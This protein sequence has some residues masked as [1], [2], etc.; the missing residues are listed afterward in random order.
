MSCHC[1]GHL[2]WQSA[3]CC[4]DESGP[5]GGGEA[6]ADEAGE[7]DAVGLALASRGEQVAAAGAGPRVVDARLIGDDAVAVGRDAIEMTGADIL[8]VGT[9]NEVEA[10][11]QAHPRRHRAAQAEAMASIGTVAIA[12][13]S[14][15]PMRSRAQAIALPKTR[16]A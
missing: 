11:E 3:A 14:S 1:D 10:V 13:A 16:R 6:T 7:R 12:V 9:D 4:V 5:F 15:G 2:R 8:G